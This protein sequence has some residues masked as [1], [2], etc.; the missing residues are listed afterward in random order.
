[1]LRFFAKEN[2]NHRE[3]RGKERAQRDGSQIMEGLDNR[4]CGGLG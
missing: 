1:L 3:H 4:M 2:A